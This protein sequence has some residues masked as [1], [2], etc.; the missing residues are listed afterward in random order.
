MLNIINLLTLK[1]DFCS[2]L[3]YE[4]PNDEDIERFE[5]KTLELFVIK[6]GEELPKHYLN[7]DGILLTCVFEKIIGVSSIEFDINPF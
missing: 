1:K 5:K 6:D 7:G 3:R 2:E 4:Y